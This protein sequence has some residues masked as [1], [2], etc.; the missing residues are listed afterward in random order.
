MT[1]RQSKD[2]AADTHGRFPERW[3]GIHGL[4]LSII[5]LHEKFLQFDWLRAVVFQLNLKY[6][7]VKITTLFVGSCINNNSMIFGINNTR[8]ISKLSQ[9][10][11]T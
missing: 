9:I 10:S 3:M 4:V 2:P 6:L 8:E 5:L 1:S 11:L 7:Q